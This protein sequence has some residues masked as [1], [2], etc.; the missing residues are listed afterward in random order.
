MKALHAFSLQTD[1]AAAIKEVASQVSAPDIRLLVYFASPRH[2]PRALAAGLAAAY[3]GV[4]AIGCTT[5]GELVAGRMLD[6]SLVVM[7]LGSE[8]VVRAHA[9]VVRHVASDTSTAVEMAFGS[10]AAGIG[11]ALSTLDPAKYAGLVL[12][13]G[14]SGAEERLM[15][16]IGNRTNIPFVGGSAGD[17]A[18]FERTHVM[19]GE[20]AY[21]NAAVVAVIETAVPFEILK[22]QSFRILPETLVATKV[23]EPRRQVLEFN[24]KPAAQAYA[25]A[26]GVNVA[27]LPSRF[28]RNPVGLVIEGEPFVRSPQRVEGSSVYFYCS[29]LEGTELNVL[30]STDLVADTQAALAKIAA[31]S[32]IIDFDC[33]LR[34]LELKQMGR[35]ETYARLF[36]GG[37]MIGFS[38]YGEEYLGHINQTATMLV[39]RS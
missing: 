28:M 32:A 19:L 37:P 30:E 15:D 33:I 9:A 35:G 23:N 24:G 13:D 16:S 38:T 7:A 39:F 18:K 2:E 5:A 36:A 1:T 31:P 25:D 12:V 6:H 14:L 22:T 26:L 34:V 8:L 11:A 17:D 29:I 10:L 20:Q 3:P 27:N 4:P 21:S